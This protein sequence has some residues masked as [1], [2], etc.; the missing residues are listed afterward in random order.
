MP[1]C[2]LPLEP[3]MTTCCLVS[4][5]KDGASASIWTD[6]FSLPKLLPRLSLFSNNSARISGTWRNFKFQLGKGHLGTKK[7]LPNG[8]AL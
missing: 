5:Q 1:S 6:S 8:R 7:A 4:S 2:Q 3:Y